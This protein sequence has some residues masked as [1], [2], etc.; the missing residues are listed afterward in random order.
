MA[1]AAPNP[2]EVALAQ[3]RLA[4][5]DGSTALRGD[6]APGP[7]RA[8]G[9]DAPLAGGV[10]RPRLPRCRRADGALINSAASEPELGSP[11][12]GGLPSDHRR[13]DGRR[14][15]DHRAQEL[16]ELAPALRYAI[17]MRGGPTEGE[18]AA[19]RQ[20]PGADR[21]RRACASR[22][23]GTTWA[24]APPAATM[25]CWRRSGSPDDARLPDDER[26]G[27][28]RR[29]GLGARTG[30]IYTGIATAARDYAIA[31]RPQPPA[32]RHARPDRRVADDPASGR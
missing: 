19:P 2:L 9:R 12:R 6:D 5:G 18:A 17:V 26:A 22:R 24:C 4:R 27:A 16:D 1:G 10:V 14:L 25:S 13:R 32:D 29:P 28:G 3:E 30:A 20:L 15:A 7:G 11:S 8:A 23:P 31:L 21:T